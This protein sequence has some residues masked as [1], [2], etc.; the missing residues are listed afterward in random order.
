MCSR[1]RAKRPG[2]LELRADRGHSGPAIFSGQLRWMVDL[3]NRAVG[4]DGIQFQRKP[5][6]H[7]CKRD[8]KGIDTH[9]G[10][11]VH[12]TLLL[13]TFLLFGICGTL[14]FLYMNATEKNTP[15]LC[16]AEH[17]LRKKYKNCANGQREEAIFPSHSVSASPI[18]GPDSCQL[19]DLIVVHCAWGE[20]AGERPATKPGKQQHRTSLRQVLESSRGVTGN[21]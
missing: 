16:K 11:R 19:R 20:P 2:Q 10:V 13:R 12:T 1:T 4:Q 5:G 17:R 14:V 7:T 6:R 9:C 18:S 21:V 15:A 8:T 3:A